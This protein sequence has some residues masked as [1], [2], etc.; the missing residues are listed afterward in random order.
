MLFI[1]KRLL[2]VAHLWYG[3]PP[4]SKGVDFLV[5]NQSPIAYPGI[6]WERKAT[7]VLDLTK[8]EETLF[9]E[10]K[11]SYRTQ[12]R[13]SQAAKNIVCRIT[14]SPDSSERERFYDFYD[15]FARIK[16]LSV[17]D[18]TLLEGMAR[19]GQ[20]ALASAHGI[21]P[22]ED[23]PD[24][25]VIISYLIYGDRARGL[26]SASKRLEDLD[27]EHLKLIGRA[28]RLLNWEAI[29]WARGKGLRLYD[30]GGWYQ[31]TEDAQRLSINQFKNGFGGERI[32]AFEAIQGV[33]VPGKVGVFFRNLLKGH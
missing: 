15:R 6:R 26:Y 30:F 7:L 12:I 23:A 24:L 2:R 5:Y 19:Q 22:G 4:P 10:M 25:L 9:S 21:T 31:G 11:K 27:P 32:T 18:R 8:S 3:D 13:R 20:L 28:N 17:L 14:D 33:T 29:R 1:R 16:G